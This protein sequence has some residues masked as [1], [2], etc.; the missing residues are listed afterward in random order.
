MLYC[1]TRLNLLRLMQLLCNSKHARIINGLRFIRRKQSSHDT[2]C[3]P[4]FV[5][6][7]SFSLNGSR[8]KPEFFIAY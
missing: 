3:H 8:C 6:T 5:L 1:D 4:I 7:F 2:F